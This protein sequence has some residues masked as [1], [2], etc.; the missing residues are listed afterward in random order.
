[1]EKNKKIFYNSSKF[2]LIKFRKIKK[3]EEIDFIQNEKGEV[4]LKF[5]KKLIYSIVFS[6]RYF[7]GFCFIIL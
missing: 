1:M 2:F 6:F 3:G 5:E 4:V 7:V